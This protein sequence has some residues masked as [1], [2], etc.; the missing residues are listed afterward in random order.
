MINKEPLVS[1]I[2]PCYNAE[3]FVEQAVRSI[4]EQ[5]YK[6]LEIICINDCSTDKTGEIL[7]KLSREDSRIIYV[8]NEQN[9]KLI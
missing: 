8:K 7:Q 2:I 3:K 4:I 5:T 9:L 1:I 6:N